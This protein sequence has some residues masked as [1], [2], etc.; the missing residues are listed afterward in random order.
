MSKTRRKK[1]L[2]R[3]YYNETRRFFRWKRIVIVPNFIK[4]VF[5]TKKCNNHEYVVKWPL[6]YKLITYDYAKALLSDEENIAVEN[7]YVYLY[8]QTIINKI[9]S[10]YYA[11]EYSNNML[12]V[13][14]YYRYLTPKK[15]DIY[16]ERIQIYH[17]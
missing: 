9:V 12:K 13:F 15:L 6:A 7:D 16:K 5:V 10:K 8:P 11:E 14:K 1:V 4:H 2:E 17:E 3:K